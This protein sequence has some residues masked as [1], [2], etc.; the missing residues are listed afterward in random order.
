MDISVIGQFQVP[1][2]LLLE[3]Y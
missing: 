3:K 1:A 2:T